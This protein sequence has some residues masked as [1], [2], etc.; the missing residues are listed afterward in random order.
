MR[1]DIEPRWS[2]RDRFLQQGASLTRF[3]AGLLEEPA[4]G[5]D[6]PW[7]VLSAERSG[8]GARCQLVRSGEIHEQDGSWPVEV[9]KRYTL[10]GSEIEL[11]YEVANAGLEVLRTR[12]LIPLDLSLGPNPDAFE[13]RCKGK[14]ASAD[15]VAEWASVKQL[16]VVGSHGEANIQ[17]DGPVRVWRY[18][19]WGTSRV[20][21]KQ[22]R[23]LQGVA[24][25]IVWL[26]QLWVRENASL[27]L[28]L[29]FRPT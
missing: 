1:E 19:I 18:P 26:V 29:S 17:V 28:R 3:E 9:R 14:R 20:D 13:L 15:T 7:Q 4:T 25:G 11:R 10:R 21:G 23:V 2:F 5:F 8:S 12:V 24:L 6:G 27:T 22:T 16:Q